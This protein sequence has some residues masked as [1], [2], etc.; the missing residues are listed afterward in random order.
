MALPVYLVHQT[1]G[2]V[3]AYVVLRSGAHVGIAVVA[4]VVTTTALSV[5]I[6]EALRRTPLR[7]A[8]GLVHANAKVAGAAVHRG[9]TDLVASPGG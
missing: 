7:A 4:I 2:V 9:G 6:A 3:C 8:F 1:V 5:L